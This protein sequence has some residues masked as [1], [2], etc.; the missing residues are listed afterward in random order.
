M[1]LCTLLQKH[2][3]RTK[4]PEKVIALTVDHGVRE[5]SAKE[6]AEVG[7]WVKQLGTLRNS[8]CD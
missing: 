6:A 2:R 7:R 4:W 5:E 1:A 8:S 3:E